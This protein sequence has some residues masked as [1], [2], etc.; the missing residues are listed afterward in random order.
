LRILS[1]VCHSCRFLKC[2]RGP[3][4]AQEEAAAS[5]D[6]KEAELWRKRLFYYLDWLFQKD[7]SAGAEFAGLQVQSTSTAHPCK[8]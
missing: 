5:G 8:C 2:K 1:S 7:S 6:S 4:A 3:Q